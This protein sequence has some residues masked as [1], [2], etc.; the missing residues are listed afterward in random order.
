MM[1]ILEKFGGKVRQFRNARGMSQQELSDKAELHR[2]YIS[3]VE[4]GEKNISLL[5]KKNVEKC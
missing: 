2:N 5:N 3:K 1:D 4:R